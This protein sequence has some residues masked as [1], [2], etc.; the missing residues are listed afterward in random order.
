[1]FQYPVKF[2]GMY[3]QEEIVLNVKNTSESVNRLREGEKDIL[4]PRAINSKCLFSFLP[5]LQNV[6]EKNTK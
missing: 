5:N 4:T 6:Q 2:Y 3:D 1:M